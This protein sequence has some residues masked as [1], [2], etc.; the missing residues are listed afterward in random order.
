MSGQGRDIACAPVRKWCYSGAACGSPL[1][2]R[3]RT[4]QNMRIHQCWKLFAGTQFIHSDKLVTSIQ[5][6]GVD[7][8][9][10]GLNSRLV[11]MLSIWSRARLHALF[12]DH[13]EL[14]IVMTRLLRCVDCGTFWLEVIVS[15]CAWSYKYEQIDIYI[16]TI[17]YGVHK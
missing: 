15:L 1:G 11:N 5:F 16:V 13:R 14:A 9:D 17:R 12:Q 6:R 10:K 8:G 7:F 2:Y 3:Y 4:Q